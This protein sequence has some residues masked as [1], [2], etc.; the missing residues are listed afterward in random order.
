MM[1]KPAPSNDLPAVCKIFHI[2]NLMVMIAGVINIEDD[3]VAGRMFITWAK[4]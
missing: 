4:K 3:V 1:L 2:L